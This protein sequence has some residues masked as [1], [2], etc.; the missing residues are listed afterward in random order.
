MN[1]TE[2]KL[3]ELDFIKETDTDNGEEYSYFVYKFDKN[4]PSSICLITNAS[5]E[6]EEVNGKKV[7]TVEIFNENGFGYCESVDEVELL[8]STIEK[9]KV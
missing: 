8:I 9:I 4:N 3:L 6:C 1:L 2:K 7:Y 5:D